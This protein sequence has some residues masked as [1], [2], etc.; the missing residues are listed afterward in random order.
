MNNYANQDAATVCATGYVNT[1]V[2]N[3]TERFYVDLLKQSGFSAY[4]NY[5]YHSHYPD[6][7]WHTHF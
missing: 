3:S 1:G 4:Q 5:Y 6:Y 7:F 2:F